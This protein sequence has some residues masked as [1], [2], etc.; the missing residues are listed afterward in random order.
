MKYTL[1]KLE[2]KIRTTNNFKINDITIDLDL[3]ASYDFHDF[4]VSNDA[5]IVDKR[6]I[7]EKITSRLGLELDKYLNVDIVVPKYTNIDE[8]VILEYEFN[9]NDNLVC[10]FNIFFEEGSNCN[11]IIKFKSL[12]KDRHF[13]FFKENLINKANSRGSISIVNLLNNDSISFLSIQ[14]D[15]FEN[16]NISHNIIDLGGTIRINNIYSN[17]YNNGSNII[18]NLYIGI[19]ENILD[20][21]YYLKNIGKNS[22]NSLLL[23]GSLSDN[24]KKNFRGIIDL[25]KGAIKSKGLENENCV[26]LTDTCRSRSLPMLL[27]CEE[28]VEGAHGVSTGKVDKDK[29]FYLMSR[30]Y[31]KKE[32]E[33]LIVESRF[34]AIINKIN[35]EDI[36]NEILDFIDRLLLK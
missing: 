23:E 25:L 16:S 2:D 27:C 18:N 3:P 32:A 10:N 35:N 36:R 11:L 9:N 30:G 17:V 34:Y 29:L 5:I 13:N 26:L 12:N 8:D 24:S 21:N 4:K 28:D 1:N 7:E 19:N 6:I 33:K 20:M 31:S 15:V 14:N 22:L